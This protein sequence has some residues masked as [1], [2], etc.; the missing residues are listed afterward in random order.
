MTLFIYFI[1]KRLGCI[2]LNHR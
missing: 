2:A 1:P